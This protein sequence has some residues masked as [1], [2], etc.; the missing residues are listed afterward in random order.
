M[1]FIDYIKE[2]G[3]ILMHDIKNE[4][5]FSSIGN[6]SNYYK[7]GDVIIGWGLQQYGLPPT[8]I[9]PNLTELKKVSEGHYLVNNDNATKDRLM[10]S[11]TYEELLTRI[12][13]NQMNI[14]A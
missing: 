3:Y 9:Y 10:A 6:I 14:K 2:Q 4:G 13:N 8:L 5:V 7:K 12:E 11:M 1:T